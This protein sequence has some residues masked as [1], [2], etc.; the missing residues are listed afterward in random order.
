LNPPTPREEGQADST[1][2]NLVQIY[3]PSGSEKE[4]VHYLVRRMQALH[5]T[6]AFVDPAGNAVGVMGSGARQV[7]LL[8]HIDT[9]PGEIPVRITDNHLYGRGAVD[10]KGPLAAFVEAAARTGAHPG[11]Q[12]VVIAAVDEERDSSGARYAVDQYRPDFAIIGEPSGW[13]R[14]TL[15]YKGSAWATVT[16]HRPT[17]HTASQA[18]SACEAAV[19]I[20]ETIQEWAGAYN[21]GRERV[22]E[23]V[24][25]TLRG[26]SS[27][28][29][30]FNEWASLR[31][32]V[33]LPPGFTPENWYTQLNRLADGA[34][35]ET[36]GFA[37]PAYRGEKNTR[38]ARAFLAGIRGR[39][40]KAGFLLKSG[41]ADL[42]IVA[43]QWN[44]PAVA[45]GPGDS[46]LDHTPDEHI[47][48]EEYARTI[49]VLQNVLAVLTQAA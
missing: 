27:G 37:V 5:F 33:R 47:S 13:E 44:C 45:Y 28:E 32:G 6:Q 40:G 15:G 16:L 34:V 20:W 25:P 4:A 21:H 7:A 9:V 41:T 48:L 8:G 36:Q 18:E 43:P 19:G 14:V 12:I 49:D 42:N 11:W 39:G 23:Q 17:R 30:G 35:V 46:A 26:I 10:A 31:V 2:C 29:D 24:Q 1:L 22:F 3:S 38:L